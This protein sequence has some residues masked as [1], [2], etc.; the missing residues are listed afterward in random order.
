M[1]TTSDKSK[2]GG[3][4][5]LPERLQEQRD[6]VQCT[7]DLNY[8]VSRQRAGTAVQA[9]A[10][11]FL[12]LAGGNPLK[13]RGGTG[14]GPLPPAQRAAVR[15]QH[16][17]WP[18]RAGN[19][20]EMRWP[21]CCLVDTPTSTCRPDCMLAS[22]PLGSALALPHGAASRQR[23]STTP[24]PTPLN[25]L[26]A[27]TRHHTPS[28]LPPTHP[29]TCFPLTACT[30][31]QTSIPTSANVYMPLGVDNA[32]DFDV[33]AGS[34]RVDVASCSG[35]EMEFDLVGIDPSLA[36]ALR[37]ILIAEV[38]TMAIE[39]VF[40]VNNTSIMPVRDARWA[41]A[42]HVCLGLV[43]LVGC[44]DCGKEQC[45]WAIV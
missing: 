11:K 17:R 5:Q 22:S 29:P 20:P 42:G 24:L 13:A 28:T 4:A 35:E 8:N 25:S 27:H 18:R 37:R 39:H 31:R 2:Q 32:W 16:G 38:P 9:R 23:T 21:L 30:E 1:G 40:I 44:G 26:I 33:F 45:R 41:R 34:F 3:E 6:Y 19:P 36:N 12:S 43:D 7:P 14:V 10:T 15:G